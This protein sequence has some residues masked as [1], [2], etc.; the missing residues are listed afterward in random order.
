MQVVKAF[1]NQ[2]CSGLHLLITS[3]QEPEIVASFQSILRFKLDDN[4]ICLESGHVN[5]D[6]KVYIAHELGSNEALRKWSKTPWLNEDIQEI[7]LQ[8]A[9]RM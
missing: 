7:L 6:V 5:N 3:R 9:N 4:A 2:E 1:I 8:N